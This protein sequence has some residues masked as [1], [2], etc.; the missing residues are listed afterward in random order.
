MGSMELGCCPGGCYCRLCG[1]DVVSDW[2][3][4][5]EPINLP[6][7]VVRFHKTEDDVL[8]VMEDGRSVSL[9]VLLGEPE[10][11]AS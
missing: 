6:S 9:N 5:P 11:E 8:A 1:G 2:E 3:E 7:P 10:N 4:L